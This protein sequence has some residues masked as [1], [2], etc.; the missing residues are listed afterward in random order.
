M[1]AMTSMKHDAQLKQYYQKKK[2]EGKNSMLILN[3]IRCK[4]IS[5]VFAVISRG[6][7]YIDTHKFTT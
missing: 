7:P 5:R 6:T 4:L 3:N 2:A 1:C